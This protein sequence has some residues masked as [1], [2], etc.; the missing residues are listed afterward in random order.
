MTLD[1]LL[2][3]RDGG[4]V[5]TTTEAGIT[6]L[7][8]GSGAAVVPVHKTPLRGL[9]AVVVNP[10]GGVE[11]ASGSNVVVTLEASDAKSYTTVQGV[12][13]SE[14]KFTSKQK[15]N[16]DISIVTTEG[17]EGV[18]TVTG[19]DIAVTIA[20]ATTVASVLKAAI[21]A[22]AAA[23]ALVSVSYPGTNDGTGLP[24]LMSIKQLYDVD[25]GG[26][27]TVATFPDLA[28][29]SADAAIVANLVARRFHTQKQFV[30]SVITITNTLATG[31]NP[32]IFIGDMIPE[33]D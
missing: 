30:R 12:A 2:R 20:A 13:N 1:Q 24:G 23:S 4:A 27:E 5:I 18:V 6:T 8:Q 9:A 26:L 21:E 14:L 11:H 15:G 25:D 3:L 10:I 31:V 28:T 19:S 17:A 22:N 32:D 33:E 29:L 7:T 16:P